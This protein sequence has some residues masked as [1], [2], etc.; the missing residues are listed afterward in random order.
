MG[1]FVAIVSLTTATR[2]IVVSFHFAREYRAREVR[3]LRHNAEG[4]M[5]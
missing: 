4:G 2:R 3:L 5:R 1:H